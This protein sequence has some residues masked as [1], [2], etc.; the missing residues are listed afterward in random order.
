M[1]DKAWI[2]VF[3]RV[4]MPIEQVVVQACHAAQESGLAFPNPTPEPTSLIVIQVKNKVQLQKAYDKLED[5]GIRFVQFDEP[6][7]DFGFTAFASE[8]VFDHQR[9]VFRKYRL[10]SGASK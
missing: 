4:D 8:P 2:Y 1:N 3:V 7:W 10:F 6:S 9:S 5:S